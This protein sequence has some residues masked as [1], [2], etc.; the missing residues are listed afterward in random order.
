M[1]EGDSVVGLVQFTVAKTDKRN[2]SKVSAVVTGLNG[3]KLSGKATK[4]PVR[5]T[6]TTAK[7]DVEI[8]VKGYPEPLCAVVTSD[9]A[10]LDAT[11][12]GAVIKTTKMEPLASASPK[13]QLQNFPSE[14]DGQLVLTDLLPTEVGFGVVNTKWTF[15]KPSS[16][17]M[18]KNRATNEIELIVDTG[19]DG[20]K[21]NLSGLKLTYASKTGLFKG[22]FMV[23]AITSAQK[24]KKYK[25]SVSGVVVD[26]EGSGIAVLKRP[27]VEIPVA[28][29]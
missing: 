28:I 19:K 5:G 14:I 17:K 26:G 25:V 20:E 15:A 22:T 16:V 13:F 2:Y 1:W 6:A 23:Y 12:G 9:G 7:V 27:V 8:S 21:S 18:K 11:L 4:C 29:R 10:L 24:L 3:K